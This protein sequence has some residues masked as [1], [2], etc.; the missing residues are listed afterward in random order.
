MSVIYINPYSF[1]V[2]L[3]PDAAAYITA[4]EGPSAD[5]QA[6]EP[7]VITAINDFVVGCKADGI[8]SAIKASCIL[9]G[10]RTLSGALVPLV[11]TA[12]TNFNFGSG[13]YARK[14]GLI[15]DG[16]S[17]SLRTGLLANGLGNTSHHFFINGSTL[18]TSGSNRNFGGVYN[19]SNINTLFDLI[20][21]NALREV[22][23]GTGGNSPG[24]SATI[25]SGFTST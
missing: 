21:I 6:L 24:N 1:G 12:P 25:A 3:D 22:R 9:A 23:S 7:A 15:G 14:T 8:W 4:V 13:D 2:A 18:V 5:N 16:A 20:Q 11:G 10:A 17:K 19:G